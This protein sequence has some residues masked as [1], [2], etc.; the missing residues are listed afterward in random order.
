MKSRIFSV[1]E[2]E[3]KT[4]QNQARAGNYNQKE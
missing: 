2:T 4:G 1:G 3:W